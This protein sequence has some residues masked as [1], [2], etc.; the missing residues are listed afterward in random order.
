MCLVKRASVS[1]GDICDPD[2]RSLMHSSCF[3]CCIQWDLKEP[4]VA[5]DVALTDFW[6]TAQSVERLRNDCRASYT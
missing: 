3:M 6:E 1:P 4:S 2:L 5:L